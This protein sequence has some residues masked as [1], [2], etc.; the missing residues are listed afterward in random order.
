M[1]VSDTANWLELDCSSAEIPHCLSKLSLYHDET[2]VGMLISYIQYYS[3]S[4]QPD[5][6]KHTMENSGSPRGKALTFWRSS[7]LSTA[8]STFKVKEERTL[9]WIIGKE[10]QWQT[11][12]LGCGVFQSVKQLCS[13]PNL[14]W[15]LFLPLGADPQISE[16]PGMLLGHHVDLRPKE[17]DLAERVVGN[18]HPMQ[19]AQCICYWIRD[20]WCRLEA[21]GK[22]RI[23][24][25][26]LLPLSFQQEMVLWVYGDQL[27]NV[28]LCHFPSQAA[29]IG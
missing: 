18:P 23:H 6:E 16:C 21:E 28:D 15:H 19:V 13:L 3:S 9:E 1:T 26:G 5:G 11:T 27:I 29:N 12:R 20:L 24:V 22:H 25:G 2:G 8:T 10:I 14:N 7:M 4:H 17:P